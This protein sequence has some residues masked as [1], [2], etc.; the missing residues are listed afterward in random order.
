MAMVLLLECVATAVVER[1]MEMDREL[2]VFKTT[3]RTLTK[4]SRVTMLVIL[5][6]CT[7]TILTATVLQ[8]SCVS[9]THWR[10]YSSMWVRN[11][12]TLAAKSALDLLT[13]QNVFPVSKWQKCHR[14]RMLPQDKWLT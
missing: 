1:A 2:L 4:P 14:S 11:A 6:S 13:H 5:A 8:T 9:T 10:S 7:D 3:L 12:R